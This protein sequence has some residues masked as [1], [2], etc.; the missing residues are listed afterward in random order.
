MKQSW[1]AEAK[2]G[3]F[4]RWG[5]SSVRAIPHPRTSAPRQISYL[6]Y[7]EQLDGFTAA[8]YNPEAWAELFAATGAKYAVMTAKDHDGVALW[9]TAF[10]ELSVT[11]ATPAGRDL[12]RPFTQ[13]LRRRGLR[14]G[15]HFSHQDGHLA[16][17]TT[18]RPSQLH[19]PA[20]QSGPAAPQSQH[21]VG[22]QARTQRARMVDRRQIRELVENYQPDLLR[23]D[24]TQ[25]HGQERLWADQLPDIIPALGHEAVVIGRRDTDRGRDTPELSTPIIPPDGP[26]ELC[27]PLGG[28]SGHH[29]ATAHRPTVHELIRVFADTIASGGNLLLETSPRGDGTIPPEHTA[30]LTA[31][32]KWVRR[33][34]EAIYTTTGVPYG[35]FDGPSTL[36]KDR[37]TLYLICTQ[38]PH[39]FIELRGLRNTIRRIS[40]LST[41]AALPYHVNNGLPDWGIPRIIRIKPPSAPNVVAVELNGELGLHQSHGITG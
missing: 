25:E 8:R 2:L 10:T 18:A 38:T 6:E 5:I 29:P 32:G 11:T 26:W 36:A 20:T 31:L 4:A 41:G 3:I 35:H 19:R 7:M 37:R 12:I 39:G 28:I 27:Y 40:V 1:F 17:Q 15:L 14:A 16:S 13:A 9:D 30:Q 21:D 34:H 22:R 33:N 23:F 24:S